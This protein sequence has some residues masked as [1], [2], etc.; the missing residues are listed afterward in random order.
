MYRACVNPGEPMIV[1]HRLYRRGSRDD[2]EERRGRGGGK[3]REREGKRGAQQ[4]PGVARK[5]PRAR[6]GRR[7]SKGESAGE[8]DRS[9]VESLLRITEGPFRILFGTLVARSTRIRVLSPRGISAY[10][11]STCGTFT[12]SSPTCFYIARCIV[13]FLRSIGI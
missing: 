6:E 10:L 1:L 9:R 4:Q 11:A 13:T 12:F 7:P 2:E 3:G 8:G 5:R